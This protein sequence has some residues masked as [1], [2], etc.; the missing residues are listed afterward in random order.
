MMDKHLMKKR[1]EH[2]RRRNLLAKQLR[3]DRRYSPK[4]HE[5]V[6]RKLKNARK[7]EQKEVR[8]YDIEQR[9]MDTDS[10]QDVSFEAERGHLH[11][12]VQASRMRDLG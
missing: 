5:D 12:Q 4:V 7:Q 1:A 11:Q 2:R 10:R 6:R 3:T 9:E 8:E